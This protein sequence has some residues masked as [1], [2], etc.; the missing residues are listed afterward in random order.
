M[1]KVK[2]RFQKILPVICW[3]FFGYLSTDCWPVVGQHM[4]NSKAMVFLIFR[5]K[6]STKS[7]QIVC[8]QLKSFVFES[9]VIVNIFLFIALS[10]SLEGKIYL[11]GKLYKAISSVTKLWLLSSNNW[12]TCY[13]QCTVSGRNSLLEIP[14]MVI[15]IY[16]KWF[17]LTFVNYM[18]VFSTGETRTVWFRYLFVSIHTVA[19]DILCENAELPRY[20][21]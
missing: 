6:V 15:A 8:N 16:N 18:I 7:Q 21:E 1:V 2:N 12:S 14:S 9:H 19:P 11:E 20:C 4:V 5:T 3:I 17:C 13:R 10:T